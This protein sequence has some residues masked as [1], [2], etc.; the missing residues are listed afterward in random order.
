VCRQ[1]DSVRGRHSDQLRTR[2][3][4]LKIRVSAVRSV[5][6]RPWDHQLTLHGVTRPLAL[7]IDS[8]K[9]IPDHPLLK[10]EACGGMPS[11]PS[12]APISE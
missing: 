9:C 3:R 6:F 11:A 8:F 2:D 1:L 4:V 12:T 7:A 5:R 10:R